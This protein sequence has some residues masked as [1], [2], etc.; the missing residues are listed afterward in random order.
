[1]TASRD[2]LASWDREIAESPRA[3]GIQAEPCVS[4]KQEK[5]L[6]QEGPHFQY[7]VICQ[8]FVLNGRVA[9]EFPISHDGR[10]EDE[11]VDGVSD[12]LCR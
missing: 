7:P 3:R 2:L 4:R 6:L 9:M 5:L 1:V 12:E 8:S 10:A 11:V